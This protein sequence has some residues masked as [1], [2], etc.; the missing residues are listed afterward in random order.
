MMNAVAQAALSLSAFPLSVLLKATVILG[1]AF[2][3]L[4]GMRPAAASARHPVLTAAFGVL[5]VL[6]AAERVLPSI[7]IPIDGI[8]T[9]PLLPIT[10][11]DTAADVAGAAP[12]ARPGETG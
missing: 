12:L 7:G 4:R 2:L 1:V 6:P 11:V 3:I 9:A 5:T 10:R 8:Q